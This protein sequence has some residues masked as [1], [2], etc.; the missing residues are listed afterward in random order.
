MNRAQQEQDQ[1]EQMRL[2]R[3]LRGAELQEPRD[4]E[5]ERRNQE[6]WR[7]LYEKVRA[8]KPKSAEDLFREAP[9]DRRK[10]ETAVP[11]RDD[12]EGWTWCGAQGGSVSPDK[13][14]CLLPGKDGAEAPKVAEK[15]EQK[16]PAAHTP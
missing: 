15:N 2:D 8:E 14:H 16:D 5:Q 13:K 1:R 9:N 7:V 10:A 3:Q 6:E 11:V 12:A 4:R